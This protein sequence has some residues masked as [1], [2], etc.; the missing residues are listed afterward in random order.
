MNEDIV[1]KKKSLFK[2]IAFYILIVGLLVW[3]VFPIYWM[4]A[5]AFKPEKL[6]YASPPKFVFSW[7]L[8]NFQ[9]IFWKAPILYNLFNTAFV[10]VIST[11]ICIVFGIFAAYALARFHFPLKENLAFTILT[12]RMMPPIAAALPFFIIFRNL[13]LLDTRFSLIIAYTNMNLP[14]VIWMLRD[15]IAAIPPEPEEAAMVDGKSRMGAFFSVTFPNLL[16]SIA[17]VS[18]LTIIFAWNEFLFALV[19][20]SRNSKTLPLAMTEF[21]TWGN[22]GW[23]HVFASSVILVIPVI[24]F[25]FLVQKYLVSGLTMGAVRQ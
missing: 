7:T 23:H 18:I 16:P 14:F 22:P 12:F 15:F 10:A 2:S 13:H 21:I 4:V 6:L 19:L 3:S 9:Y 24:L 5:T 1:G 17:A 25:S 8:D 11:F 20:T